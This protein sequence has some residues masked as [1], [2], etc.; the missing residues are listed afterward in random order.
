M[1]SDTPALLPCPFCGVQ[2]RDAWDSDIY[3]GWAIACDACGM[4]MLPQAD[5]RA[6]AITAWNCRDPAALRL[7]GTEP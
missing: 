6:E 3:G 5:N 4:T 1:P 2:P 7:A